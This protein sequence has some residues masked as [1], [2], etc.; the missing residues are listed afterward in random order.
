MKRWS[1][2]PSESGLA[3]ICQLPRGANLKEDGEILAMVRPLVQ[4]YLSVVG[5]YWY[6]FGLN[7]CRSPVNTLDEAKKQVIKHIKDSLTK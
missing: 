4:D 6:G 3:R 2:E 5:W 7:T 1:K